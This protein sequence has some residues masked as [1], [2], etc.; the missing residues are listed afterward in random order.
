MRSVLVLLNSSHSSNFSSIS[1]PSC[2]CP[3]HGIDMEDPPQFE[4]L[5]LTH[6]QY[7]PSDRLSYI[8]AWLALAPQGLCVIYVTLIWASREIEILM[9][10]AG[11][12]ACESLNWILKR[13]IKEDR[14]KRKSAIL[15]TLS[16]SVD[17][18][19]NV[20][21]GLWY[22][23]ITF[24]VCGL[25]LSVADSLP[26]APSSDNDSHILFTV[27]VCRAGWSISSVPYLC[28]LCCPVSNLPWLPHA[29]PSLGRL[30]RWSDLCRRLVHDHYSASHYWLV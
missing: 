7:D 17:N 10:F 20:W 13:W 30:R 15:R 4:S 3:C 22:A 21:E 8:S 27:N 23:F 6:V 11:Q 25:L 5:S 12:M 18:R 9:M 29:P 28:S 14:P 2:S 19:R 16:A 1:Y 26:I 24:A